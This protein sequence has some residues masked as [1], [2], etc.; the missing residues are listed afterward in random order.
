M[1]TWNEQLLKEKTASIHQFPFVNEGLCC[2]GGLWVTIP[3]RFTP[4]IMGARRWTTSPKYLVHE[5]PSGR[6]TFVCI[7]TI[8]V[9]WV[10]VGCIVNGPTTLDGEPVDL[11]AFR[12]LLLWARQHLFVALRVTHPEE[13]VLQSLAAAGP[14]ERVDGVPF[15]PRTESELYVD[16]SAGENSL[17]AGFQSVA[18]QEIRKA[19]NA[20]Y[21]ISIDRSPDAMEKAW[22][23]FASRSSQ[24]GIRYRTLETYM[25]IMR[26][27]EPHCAAHL[28]T[29]WLEEHPI[30]AILTLRDSSTVHYFLGTIDVNALGNAPSPMVLLQ[31]EAMHHAASLGARFYNLGT[32]SGSVYK[33]KAKFRPIEYNR[34]IPLTFA[35][36]PF[37]YRAWRRILPLFAQIVR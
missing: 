12:N 9:P 3:G 4:L 6:R 36:N 19:H 34:P 33:F 14:S 30:A 28:F 2:S 22:P 27:A 31:W 11:D 8:G 10:R 29:A 1:S 25:R 5:S 37:L 24:K 32:R 16:L 13:S 21:K 23:A 17:L 26:A 35:V 20:G 7:V 15:Y 18:R